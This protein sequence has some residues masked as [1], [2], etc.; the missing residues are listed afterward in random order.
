MSEFLTS[1]RK[2]KMLM[3]KHRRTAVLGF[4]A[5]L[6]I[7][8]SLLLMRQDVMIVAVS[9]NMFWLFKTAV[10]SFGIV[11]LVLIAALND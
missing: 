6:A 10:V 9:D 1:K 7:V 2:I 11:L 4:M 5:C 3:W 8:T